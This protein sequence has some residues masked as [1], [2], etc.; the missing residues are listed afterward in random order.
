MKHA[1]LIMAHHDFPVLCRLISVIDDARNDIYIHFDKKVESFPEM[2][3]Q[4][5]K[6]IVVTD[7]MDVRWG[8]FSQIE[9]ELLLFRRAYA[10][11]PYAYYH[12]LS[13]VDLPLKNQDVIHDFFDRHAGKEFIGMYQGDC[14]KEIDRKVRHYH[15]FSR[16]FR[17]KPTLLNL[18][19]SGLRFICL[20]A[21]Y[22]LSIKRNTG[23]SFKKGANWV[24]VTDHFVAY[25]ITRKSLIKSVFRYSFCADEIFIQTICW[26][27]PF[28]ERLFHP[29][30][31][32]AG[33]LRKIGWFNNAL[34]DWELDDFDLLVKSD[35]LFARKFTSQHMDV[36]EKIVSH[37]VVGTLQD[38]Q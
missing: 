6:L 32:E 24:S 36:I 31:E 23:I 7:R 20:R 11:G 35:A 16:H 19:R 21:Q 12:L 8:D 37:I 17:T 22:A 25:L 14:G 4:H 15:L 1:Y 27:S 13:G 38:Q 33:S 2:K 28:R 10:N 3:V 26:N 9:T 34:R 5:A 30:H 29:D 18:F